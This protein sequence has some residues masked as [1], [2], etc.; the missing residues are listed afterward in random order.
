[1]CHCMCVCVCRMDRETEAWRHT[2]GIKKKKKQK[3]EHLTP[4]LNMKIVG[5]QS[6]K[7]YAE[8]GM[9]EGEGR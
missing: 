2:E 9:N 1:M 8:W 5:L 6:K 7:Q 3:T 4:C